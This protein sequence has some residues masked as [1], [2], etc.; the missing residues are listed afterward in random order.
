MGVVPQ[1]NDICYYGGWEWTVYIIFKICIVCRVFH[2]NHTT[3]ILVQCIIF[4]FGKCRAR[5]V[6]K[7]ILFNGLTYNTRGYLVSCVVLLTT[8]NT[9]NEENVCKY[10]MLNHRIRFIVPLQKICYFAWIL[11]GK[12][13]YKMHHLSFR[14]CAN[15]VNSTKGQPNIL[16]LIG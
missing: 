11:F 16:Y 15:D 2:Q 8:K 14:A 5:Q 12:S 6:F 3:L 10:Y 9:S 13:V 1:E 4:Q 7:Y